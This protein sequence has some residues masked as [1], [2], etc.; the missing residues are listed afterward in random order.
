MNSDITPAAPPAP[1]AIVGGALPNDV[2]ANLRVLDA[3]TGLPIERVLDADAAAGTVRRYEV[4]DGN[5]VRE[6]DS[7]K[8]V[9]EQRAIR[10]EWISAP[11]APADPADEKV[12]G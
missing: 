8:I 10:I 2:L 5:L 1:T 7:Y 9:D 6:G 3:E 12:A 4:V 11:T